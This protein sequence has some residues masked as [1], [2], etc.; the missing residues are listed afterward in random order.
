MKLPSD[1]DVSNVKSEQ[2]EAAPTDLSA[3]AAKDELRGLG[4]LPDDQN[5]LCESAASTVILYCPNCL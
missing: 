3:I 4:Y 2:N 5:L 1:E